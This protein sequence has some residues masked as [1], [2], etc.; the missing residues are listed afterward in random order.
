MGSEEAKGGVRPKQ[1]ARMSTRVS[2]KKVERT[3]TLRASTPEPPLQLINVSL[4]RRGRAFR[5]GHLPAVSQQVQQL[6]ALTRNLEKES[7]EVEAAVRDGL[8]ANTRPDT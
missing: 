6:E 1:A 5:S 8:T 7:V 3:P 2:T 4:P